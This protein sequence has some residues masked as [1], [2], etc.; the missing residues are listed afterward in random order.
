[1]DR[2]DLRG[3]LQRRLQDSSEGVWSETT[4][5]TYINQGARKVATMLGRAEP[6]HVLYTDLRDIEGGEE[7]YLIPTNCKRV[8]ELWMLND[9][10]KYERLSYRRRRDQ[11]DNVSTEPSYS[12]Q[13]RFIK[14][15]PEP[16]DDVT[17]G[18]KLVYVPI[19]S[20]SSDDDSFPMSSDMD[21]GVVLEAQL[22][23]YGDTAEAAD[24]QAVME[25]LKNFYANIVIEE[26]I[27]A[28][29]DEFLTFPKNL[30]YS[31]ADLE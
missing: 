19:M 31:S 15:D 11:A 7:L 17:D 6:E 18:L 9:N 27:N 13:G 29:A 21:L 8:I 1:M 22:L 5:N 4:L 16:E 3:W 10:G 30:R 24:K 12:M 2:A 20:L 14:L 23:A 26:D 28:D 25:E